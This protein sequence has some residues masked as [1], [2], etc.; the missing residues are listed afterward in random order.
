MK[1]Q[2]S[3][4]LLG[5]GAKG[6]DGSSGLQ[7]LAIY[8]TDFNP[9]SDIIPIRN[10]IGNSEV[11]WSAAAPGTK[12]PG[13]RNYSEG[14]L[15]IDPRGFVYRITSPT[16]GDYINTGMTLS[17]S[18]FFTDSPWFSQTLNGFNRYF[19]K[20]DSPK[21]IIDNVITDITAINYSSSPSKIYGVTPKNFARIEYS[22]I[23]DVSYNAF[24]IYSS[25]QNV[26]TD[27][28]KS[29][30]IVKKTDSN[31]FHIGNI[32]NSNICRDVDLILDVS[33]LKF[34][35]EI[36]NRFNNNTIP[37]TVLTN[38][39]KNSNSLFSDFFITSPASFIGVAAPTYVTLNWNLS[40]FTSGN[41]DPSISGI[42]Y[43][44]KKE[45]ASGT[46]NLD[47]SIWRPLTF[48]NL[49]NTGSLIVS[50]LTLG[51]TYE[52][53]VSICKNGWERNSLI[54]QITT[55]NT[56]SIFTII[57]PSPPSLNANSNGA[58]IPSLSFKY[59][60]M[61]TT[62]SFTGWNMTDIPMPNWITT[63][64][65]GSPDP[66][67]PFSGAITSGTFTFD[68][69]LS[70]FNGYSSRTGIITFIS[71]APTQTITIT[72]NR[73]PP[74]TTR[75]VYMSSYTDTN[76]DARGRVVFD[77]PLDPGQSVT[78]NAY[79]HV[80]ARARGGSHSAQTHTQISVYKNGI[81]VADTSA[82]AHSTSG[83]VCESQYLNFSL[84]G[85]INTDIIEVRQGPAFDCV[86]WSSG[87]NG[88]EEG[89]AYMRLDS[90]TD[91]GYDTFTVTSANKFWNVTRIACDG[92]GS[93]CYFDSWVDSIATS[94]PAC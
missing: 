31:E 8:F 81:H 63:R 57:N 17:K 85:I 42:L 53:Y 66:G 46:Y 75:Q 32:N 1:F 22:N 79:L 20:N 55:S 69:S 82:Y 33:S 25:G 41:Y 68:I 90:V 71:E 86:Y 48:H 23:S 19:N 92:C 77:P 61:V 16:A 28:H 59:N 72:Q 93:N 18:T 2:Y 27:D 44:Y 36:G 21:F 51:Q 11:L 29:L 62:N 52:Y 9:F 4:G 49:G 30:A 39:E 5:Y 37:G 40:D 50:S 78:L 14:D 87:T 54:R 26:I 15:I 88:W 91:G 76:N 64:V 80:T 12:L 38:S 89:A 13:G 84:S 43:F 60:V 94:A 83:S 65:T 34:A 7:G 6:A 73:R 24:S 35:R 45:N 67:T 3:G 10:A 47:A 74:I 70:A 58:F 56:P